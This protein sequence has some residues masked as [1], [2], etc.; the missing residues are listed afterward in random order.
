MDELGLVVVDVL[1]AGPHGVVNRLH[2]HTLEAPDAAERH[3][4]HFR[5]RT[6]VFG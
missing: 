3:L 6:L 1:G 5:I 2:E 4:E